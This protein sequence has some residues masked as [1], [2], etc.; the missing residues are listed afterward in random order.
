MW[1]DVSIYANGTKCLRCFICVVIK[2]SFNRWEE[3]CANN[4]VSRMVLSRED[5]NKMNALLYPF[6]LLT[7]LLNV[8]SELEWNLRS[9][10]NSFVGISCAFV[11]FLEH[12]EGGLN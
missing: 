2:L 4:Y 9:G 6:N 7:S 10:A 12:I 11:F 5:K 3:K 8:L 1:V